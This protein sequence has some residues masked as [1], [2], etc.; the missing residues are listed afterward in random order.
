M[1]DAPPRRIPIIAMT[2]NAMQGDRE[3]CLAEKAR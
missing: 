3:A 2:V 1:D